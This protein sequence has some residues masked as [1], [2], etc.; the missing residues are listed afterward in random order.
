MGR[1]IGGVLFAQRL[2]DRQREK[3]FANRKISGAVNEFA[4]GRLQVNEHW[5]MDAGADTGADQIR[6]Q[7]VMAVEMDD[8]GVEGVELGAAAERNEDPLV[9]RNPR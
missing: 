3:A 7:L 4:G 1:R 6:T 8:E 5:I 9:S 2:I